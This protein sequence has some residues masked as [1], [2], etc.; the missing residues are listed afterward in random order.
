MRCQQLE[1]TLMGTIF[2][3][4]T[5]LARP[6][7]ADLDVQFVHAATAETNYFLV[8]ALRL[9]DCALVFDSYVLPLSKQEDID[10]ARYLISLGC[11]VSSAPHETIVSAKVGPGK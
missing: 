6:V 1:Q 11:S 5:K 3:H 7:H 2:S 10:H 9:G 8:S 4:E